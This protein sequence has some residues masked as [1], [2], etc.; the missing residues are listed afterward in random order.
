MHILMRTTHCAV[1]LN[2]S[3]SDYFLH[4]GTSQNFYSSY[5]SE[6]LELPV[7]RIETSLSPCVQGL[8]VSGYL[9]QHPVVKLG[10]FHSVPMNFRKQSTRLSF[11]LSLLTGYAKLKNCWSNDFP[12][13]KYL[14]THALL[15]ALLFTCAG[16]VIQAIGDPKNNCCLGIEYVN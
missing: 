3:N 14:L 13:V 8:P 9:P 16:S 7:V 5:L 6:R 2:V 15:Y 10:V 1:H 12:S 4:I 11:S